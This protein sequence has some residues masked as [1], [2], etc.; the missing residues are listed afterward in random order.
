MKNIKFYFLFGIGLFL[1]LFPTMNYI[2]DFFE[3]SFVI[4]SYNKKT[5]HSSL[6]D[7]KKEIENARKYNKMLYHHEFDLSSK[8]WKINYENQLKVNS[9]SIMGYIEIKSIGVKLPI[10]HGSN[11]ATLQVGAG[12][13]EYTSLPIGGKDTHSVISAHTGLPSARMFDNINKLKIGS[14]FRL[15]VLRNV[16]T[17]KVDMIKRVNPEDVS[18]THI[19]KGKDYC[20]LITCTPLGINNKRLVIRG[21]R[22]HKCSE[23]NKYNF[24]LIPLYIYVLF[25]VISIYILGGIIYKKNKCHSC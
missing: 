23:V 16:L 13:L 17:Y 12:H 7:Y 19:R 6:I 14:T 22:V 11:E 9:S 8:K 25:M 4:A 2:Y 10:Y 1:I 24:N 20:S 3:N 5:S 15:H 21:K 18:V